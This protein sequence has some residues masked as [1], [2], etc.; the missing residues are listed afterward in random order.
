MLQVA[1]GVSSARAHPGGPAGDSAGPPRSLEALHALSAA[2]H[3][4]EGEKGHSPRASIFK[5]HAKDLHS[6]TFW[7]TVT[8]MLAFT[9]L[10]DRAQ[11]LAAWGAGN[12]RCNKMFLE[13]VTSELMM[14]GVVA[15]SVF[16][17][18]QTFTFSETGH[19]I[20]EF[21]DILCSFAACA[22]IL[23]GG[24]LFLM[25]RFVEATLMKWSLAG[26]IKAEEILRQ[27]KSMNEVSPAQQQHCQLEVMRAQFFSRN[28]L[29]IE[30]F[31][32]NFYLVETLNQ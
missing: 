15:I 13:R 5:M 9:I 18:S 23:M 14:F 1:G 24:V 32:Y 25:R 20:F 8:G 22:L 28:K 3:A 10:V 16:L 6:P 29:S 11:A 30:T 4:A 2:E 17:V 7:G 19:L 21:V 31:S 26:E 12:N 27:A